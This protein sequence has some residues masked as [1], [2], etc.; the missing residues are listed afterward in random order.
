[1][2]PVAMPH[3]SFV[4]PVTELANK[5]GD[6]EKNVCVSAH[7]PSKVK[8][9]QKRKIKADLLIPVL[10]ALSFPEDPLNQLKRWLLKTSL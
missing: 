7:K 1:M 2:P 5:K 4:T 9:G 3:S 10:K 6:L 8:N